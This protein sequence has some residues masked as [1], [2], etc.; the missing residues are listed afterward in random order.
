LIFFALLP[1]GAGAGTSYVVTNKG[2]SPQHSASSVAQYA[3]QDGAVRAAGLDARS[4][5]LFKDGRAYVIDNA[6]R[7]IQVVTSATVAQAQ[8]RMDERV[9]SVR[10]AAA[11]LPPD[12]RAVMDKMAADMQALNDS[13]RVA[14]PRE[15]RPTDRSESVDGHAC[16]IWEAFEQQSKRFDVC[17]AAEPA[18]PGSA[19]ILA[20]M[21]MLS[22]YWQGSVFALGIKLGNT[23]WWREIAGLHG[24]P[25]LIRE[26]N[27]GNVV[28][29][30]TL[31]AIRSNVRVA[32]MFELPQDYSRTEVAFIP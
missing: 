7:A 25:I 17:V 3:V 18:I 28:S 5:Y 10:E 2:M 20:G 30:T 14:V 19:D 13:R 16:R 29:E 1:M 4:V 8:T 24:L 15:Y 23:G 32:S 9:A 11:K 21:Q 26:F 31:T 12:K 27:D 22:G 6:A